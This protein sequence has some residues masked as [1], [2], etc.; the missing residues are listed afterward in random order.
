M[1]LLIDEHDCPVTEG[2]TEDQAWDTWR[3]FIDHLARR[4]SNTRWVYWD[5]SECRHGRRIVV[6]SGNN[7][8]IADADA[9]FR[10][11]TRTDPRQSYIG[12]C[13]IDSSDSRV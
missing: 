9:I 11:T 12:A 3:E 4:G 5:N 13:C 7:I 10:S 1:T 2:M 8:S 6:I